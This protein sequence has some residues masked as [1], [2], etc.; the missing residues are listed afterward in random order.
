MPTDNLK[1]IHAGPGTFGAKDLRSEITYELVPGQDGEGCITPLVLGHG[2]FAKVFKAWQCSAG[3]NVRPVAIKILHEHIDRKSEQLFI[4]EIRLM[5]KLTSASG[6][7]VI[8]ILDILQL[9]PM[10]MCGNCGQVYQPRCPQCGEHQLERYDPPNEAYPALRCKS[11]P[12]CKYSI[13]AEHV[14]NGSLALMQPP[15]KTCCA[16]ERGDRAQ[17]GTLINFVDRDAV[18]MELL[19]EK[20][21]QFNPRRRRAY[22]DL[23][24]QHGILLPPP[25]TDSAPATSLDAKTVSPALRPAQAQEVEF[26]QKVVLLEKLLIMMQLAEA[27]AWLHGSQV[28][29][30]KDLAPD[31]I[32]ITAL[33]SD[34]DADADWRGFSA[35]SL[36]EALTSLANYQSF[37]AKLIDFGLA[38]QK[39]LTRNWYE[40]PIASFAADKFAY[41][42]LEA[43]HRK[44]LLYQR[45]DLDPGRRSFLV[46]DSLRPD[47]AGE[48]AIKVGDLLIDESD[49]AHPYTL[50]VDSV[51]QDPVEPHVF[52]ATVKGEV[53]PNASS[54][55]FY[56][57]L[58]LGEAHDI[59]SLGAVFYFILT[60]DHT[61]V[62]KLT[63][64]ANILQDAPQPLRADYLASRVPNYNICRRGLPEPYYQDELMVLILRAMVRG[65]EESYA[66]SRTQRGSGPA[67]RLLAETR[68]IYNLVKSELL[69][70]PTQ[71]DLDLLRAQYSAVSRSHSALQDSHAVQADEIQLLAETRDRLSQAIVESGASHRRR[72]QWLVALALGMCAFG[73]LVTHAVKEYRLSLPGAWLESGELR[74]PTAKVAS[75]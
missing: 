58:P 46:P 11:H 31:N 10:A 70:E 5:K 40:E 39:Q 18:V 48:L 37:K 50:E 21:P 29:V 26:V 59:Y 69:N 9:G 13:S 67:Q 61:A 53:P 16:K 7:N 25:F 54:R 14:L 4:Q 6:V 55:Q 74:P 72:Q 60:G 19:E 75:R 12:R 2:R 51:E 33:P 66:E 15:A 47:H 34:E 20:L 24:R 30:H 73:S 3:N 28:I 36:S 62:S 43:R 71:R 44:R 57:L 68:R 41:T 23:C 38:D 45:L 32:M 17:R 56:H 35:G 8:N 64:V 27:V 63:N 1:L 65:Q 42:S 52:R 49:P 22:F